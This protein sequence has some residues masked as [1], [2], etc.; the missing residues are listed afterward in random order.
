MF[1]TAFVFKKNNSKLEK[2][3]FGIDEF[4]RRAKEFKKMK[5]GLVTNDAAVTTDGIM[6]REAL[7]DA[8][9]S[10]VK[11]FSPEHGINKSGADGEVQNHGIDSIT[12]LPVISLYGE[13]LTLTAED[14]QNLDAI[15]FDIPDVGCRF[16]TYLW[17]M[18][19]VMKACAANNKLFIL[20]DRPN[21]LGGNLN[22]AEGPLLNEKY[23]SSFIGRW[24]LPVTHSCTF[25]ELAN[26]FWKT[27]MP[28]LN[29]EIIKIKNWNR[30]SL[31]EN[32]NWKFVPTSPAIKDLETVQLYPGMGLLEGINVNEGRGTEKDFKVFGAPWI[33]ADLLFS[34]FQ[35]LNIEGLQSKIIDYTPAWGLYANEKCYGLELSVTNAENFS[36]VITGVEIIKLLLK[37]FTADSKERLYKTNA[38]PTGER[39]LDKLIGIENAFHKL[40]NEEPVKTNLDKEAWVHIISPFLLY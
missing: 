25:G 7:L 31:R 17:T 30:N 24:A 11:L 27:R 6:S 36:P 26:Y 37:L 23:C 16:Y 10:I 33:N 40:Q 21:P 19:Y 3:Y 22:S 14:L 13:K 15:L 2:V 35:K 20:L 9:V 8:S 32:N 38:N 34:G 4:I 28:N 39:H 29:C 12:N 1:K 5:F 18:T